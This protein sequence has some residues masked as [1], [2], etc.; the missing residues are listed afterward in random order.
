MRHSANADTEEKSPSRLRG[1]VRSFTEDLAGEDTQLLTPV[2]GCDTGSFGSATQTLGGE[3]ALR[4][5]ATCDARLIDVAR[6]LA[7]VVPGAHYRE[8]AG[9]THNVKPGV[10]AP[11]AVEFLAS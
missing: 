4:C 1:N 10:L 11:A 2:I 3:V 8:L 9:Q 5:I 6:A 7:N